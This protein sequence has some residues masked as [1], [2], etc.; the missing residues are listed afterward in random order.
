M[1]DDVRGG[2]GESP[3]QE[4]AGED[5][6]QDEPTRIMQPAPPRWSARA[7]V[8]VPGEEEVLEGEWDGVDAA[9]RGP[10]GPLLIAVAVVIVLG[11]LG[12]GGWIVWSSKSATEPTPTATTTAATTPPPAT[13]TE[14]AATT[15][16]ATPSETK[17]PTVVVPPLVEVEYESASDQLIRLGLNPVRQDEPSTEVPAGLI[18]RTDPPG[19]TEV[20]V[21]S[22]IIVTVS[23]GPPAP[24][25][26]QTATISPAARVIAA[27]DAES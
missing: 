3:P 19:G 2:G 18:I 23:S 24:P 13:T 25:T 10:F 9:P 1:A 17:P 21:G 8:P 16:P 14:P 27:G 7:H 22:T 5:R 6:G 15:E 20:A 11:L 4:P 26:T 12:L